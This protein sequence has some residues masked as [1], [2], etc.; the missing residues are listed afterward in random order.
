MQRFTPPGANEDPARIMLF[1]GEYTMLLEVE[2]ARKPFKMVRPYGIVNRHYN[3][4]KKRFCRCTAGLKREDTPDGNYLIL[5]G[6]DECPSCSVAK[7]ADFMAVRKL[8][9]FNVLRLEHYHLVDSDR[10]KEGTSEYFKDYVECDGKRCKLCRK[11]AERVF[12]RRMYWPIG[13]MHVEQ[14]VDIDRKTISKR[15]ICG[16]KVSPVAFTCPACGGIFRDLDDDPVDSKKELSQIRSEEHRCQQKGC[17]YVGA[18]SEV[19]QCD[20]CRKATPLTLW[21]LEMEVYM[22]GSGTKSALTLSDWEPLTVKTRGLIK[23][24]LLTPFDWDKVYDFKPMEPKE[25]V[26]HMGIEKYAELDDDTDDSDLTGS[27][28]WGDSDDDEDLLT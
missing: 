13:P 8:H 11:G 24:N 12:G 6:N 19:S 5:P 27:E 9:V 22:S 18:M 20:S 2:G 26:K 4:A 10:K 7:S 25:Q 23:E 1:P 3:S 28:G 14:L 15:C 21:D 16:G 17:K